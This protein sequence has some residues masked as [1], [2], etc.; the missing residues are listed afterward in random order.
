MRFSCRC[1]FVSNAAF[2]VMPPH[3]EQQRG[4][5][6]ISLSAWLETCLAPFH[7]STVL[8]R[9]SLCKMAP[10]MPNNREKRR[11][12][13]STTACDALLEAR[14]PRGRISSRPTG[15]SRNLVWPKNGQEH[16]HVCPLRMSPVP[17]RHCPHRRHRNHRS[18]RLTSVVTLAYVHFTLPGS[19]I[20]A[21][22]CN[23]V[24]LCA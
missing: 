11:E 2:Y 23:K 22:V 12:S 17:H 21:A 1:A 16:A 15:I 18:I 10:A 14:T 20:G 8:S 5:A 13:R 4:G 19:P 7:R 3:K 9:V 24:L 6:F